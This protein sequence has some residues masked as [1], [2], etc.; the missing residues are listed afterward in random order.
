V[1]A[2]KRPAGLHDLFRLVQQVFEDC[3][4]T[5]PRLPTHLK[6]VCRR[7]GQEWNASLLSLSENGCLLRSPEPLPL[8]TRLELAFDLPR[9]GS[10]ELWAEIAYQLV[11]D[12]GLVFSGVDPSIRNAIGSYV[13]ASLLAG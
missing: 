3:P 7:R 8:G 9:V 11:P 10:M 1:G 12:L 13:T 4:R 6:V 2:V 5:T